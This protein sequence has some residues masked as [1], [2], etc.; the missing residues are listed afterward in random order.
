MIPK[1]DDS[2][3]TPAQR[4]NVRRHA[5]R[6]L[7]EAGAL[8]V[9]PT[10]V[11]DVLAAANVEPVDEEILNIDFLSKVRSRASKSLKRALSK[12]L[13]VF[14]AKSSL[15]FVDRLLKPVKQRFVLFH[16]A[17]HGF[18][19]W[20]RAMYDLVEDCEQALDPDAADLFD[21][22]ANVFASEVLFQNDTFAEMAADYRFEIWTPIKLSKQFDASLYASIRQYVSKSD[23]CCVVLVLNPPVPSNGGFEATLRRVVHSE[24]FVRTFGNHAWP[25]VCTATDPFGA[26]VPLGKRKASGKRKLV[27]KDL[28]GVRHECIAESF[29]QTY[30]VFILIHT[31]GTLPRP[32][33]M[34]GRNRTRRA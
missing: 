6:A 32:I 18:M 28:D 30:Q 7:Q 24:S 29:T 14:D 17:G 10:P 3:L 19:P 5:R 23:R 31:V 25:T 34:P 2:S 1:P 11:H 8:G 22:E 27:L 26:L 21:R 9:L 4:S 13:G 12:V 16:E 33:V 20:Q 15:V